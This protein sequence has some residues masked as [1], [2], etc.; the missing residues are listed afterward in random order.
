MPMRLPDSFQDTANHKCPEPHGL[1]RAPEPPG[2][3]EFRHDAIKATVKLL[4]N[5]NSIGGVTWD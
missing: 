3:A 4:Q 1:S 5:T 2:H